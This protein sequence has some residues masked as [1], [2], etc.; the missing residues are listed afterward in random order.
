MKQ[1]GKKVCA[2]I[3]NCD[4]EDFFEKRSGCDDTLN[5]ANSRDSKGWVNGR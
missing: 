4:S 3:L 2:V 5:S 1:R